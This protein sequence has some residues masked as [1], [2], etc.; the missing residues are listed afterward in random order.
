MGWNRLSTPPCCSRACSLSHPIA[1]R[2]PRPEHGAIA[3]VIG[4]QSLPL[5]GQVTNPPPF[6]PSIIPPSCPSPFHTG[7]HSHFPIPNAHAPQ[8]SQS[9]R[10]G[11]SACSRTW[12]GPRM[13][14]RPPFPCPA[15]SPLTHARAPWPCWPGPRP[16]ARAPKPCPLPT[17]NLSLLHHLLMSA[18]L[19]PPASDAPPPPLVL[20]PPRPV[21]VVPTDRCA[22]PSK[23][24]MAAAAAAASSKRAAAGGGRSGGAPSRRR[25]RRCFAL[26]GRSGHHRFAQEDIPHG[27]AVV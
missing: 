24:M 9:A 21:A 2:R 3:G 4:R 14:L 10:A 12:A 13:S 6:L 8:P 1:P 16:C 5:T 11:P 15:L 17:P 23:V 25:R 27:L 22:S 26:E 20:Q 18:R 7:T 19:C